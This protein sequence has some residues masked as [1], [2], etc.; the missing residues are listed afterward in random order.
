MDQNSRQNKKRVREDDSG[1][2]S[3]E[4]KLVRVDS[5]EKVTETS[6]DMK[7][8]SGIDSG[9][10][11]DVSSPEAKRLEDDLFN[12]FDESDEPVIQGLDSVI[13]SFEEEMLVPVADMETVNP[14]GVMLCGGCSQ[15][16]LGY[17]LKA[18]DDELG[19]P[20]SFSGEEDKVSVTDFTADTETETSRSGCGSA[21]G[22]GEMLGFEKKI[23]NYDSFEFGFGVDSV[24][25][26]YN[27]SGDFVAL[28][29][30]FD[31]SDES[32]V[33][34]EMSAVQWQPESL[35]AL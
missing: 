22:F 19:L 29:G 9:V 24:S 15:P 7:D 35:S 11:S 14:A 30:L 27:D 31:Y 34:A 13:K 1:C 2:N 26:S 6:P 4:S 25:L 21:G 32:F 12:I 17:L 23:P 33:P 28:G 10:D 18:S 8:G 20:P 16:D 5:F 3:P